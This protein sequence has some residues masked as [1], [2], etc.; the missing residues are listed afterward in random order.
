MSFLKV[1]ETHTNPLEWCK[2]LAKKINAV[3]DGKTNNTATVTLTAN[4]TTTLVTFA[5]GRIG[6][7][8]VLTFSPNTAT[9]AGAL[10]GLY[11]SGRDVAAKTI[12][13]THADTATTDRIFSCVLVG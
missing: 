6:A 2:Q 10:S 4:S 3:M 11:V 9:A 12:T 1:I 5:D 13:L 7:D 8:T